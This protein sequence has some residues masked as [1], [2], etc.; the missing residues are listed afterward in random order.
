MQASFSG[1]SPDDQT[2]IGL[3][4][5]LLGESLPGQLDRSFGS[6][7]DTSD[8]LAELDGIVLPPSAENQWLA[9]SW[10]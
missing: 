1:F 5:G 7:I 10:W 4:A 8:P 9:F 6:M 3:R 2:E